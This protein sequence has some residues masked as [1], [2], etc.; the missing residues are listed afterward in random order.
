M[1]PFD[2]DF[3]EMHDYLDISYKS[4]H[5]YGNSHIHDGFES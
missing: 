5:Y 2:V 1:E 3:D 4:I